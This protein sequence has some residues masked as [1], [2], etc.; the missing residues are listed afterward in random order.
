MRSRATFFTLLFAVSSF[1]LPLF[2]HAAA[3]PWFG[4]IVPEDCTAGFGMLVTVI[5][6]IIIVL[7]SIAI[8]FV[9]PLM[10]AYAGFLFVVNPTNPGGKEQAKSV[11]TNT[12]VGIV[13]SLAAWMIVAAIMAV[14]YKDPSSGGSTWGTWEALMTS[15]GAGDGC[16]SQAGST[17]GP[18]NPG[19]T[20]DPGVTVVPLVCKIDPLSPI[21]D[22]LAQQME[23]GQTVIWTNTDPRLQKCT[24]KF[25]SKLKAGGEANA[26]VTSAY[27]PQTYQTH[28]FEIRDRWCTQG[29]RSN[30]NSAC[31]SLE[32]DVAHE[33]AKHFGYGWNCG[34]VAV[35]SRHTAGTGVDIAGIINP[36]NLFERDA[37]KASCLDW[38][39]YQDDPYHYELMI[40]CTC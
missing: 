16:L 17:A 31:S 11:L 23:G 36:S 32:N 34:A 38:K 21:T 28:L 13:I 27:R 22:P 7:L 25:I 1:A 2:A 6:N 14:L 26:H 24:N 37:A 4:P 33:V 30:S 20:T 35:T 8:V 19:G 12:I 15:G 10:I 9:A 18:S 29:L 5:N 39:N 40:S 3:I